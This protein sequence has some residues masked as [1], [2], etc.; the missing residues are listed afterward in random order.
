MNE[1]LNLYVSRVFQSYFM[2]ISRVF[3]SIRVLPDMKKV[4]ILL[5]TDYWAFDIFAKPHKEY[6][7]FDDDNG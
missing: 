7:I 5:E 3:M 4:D 2:E 1:K 6:K